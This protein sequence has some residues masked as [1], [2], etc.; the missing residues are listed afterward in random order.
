MKYVIPA[1]AVLLVCGCASAP[2]GKPDRTITIEED[3]VTLT[4]FEAFDEDP[5]GVVVSFFTDK[6]GAGIIST[7][8]S[9]A[10]EIDPGSGS[11]YLSFRTDTELGF[12]TVCEAGPEA[13]FNYYLT[14]DT[15]RIAKG[16]DGVALDLKP[17]NFNYVNLAIKEERK[18]GLFLARVPV[19]L[20][21]N[22]W[23]HVRIPFNQFVAD[24]EDGEIDLRQP[25]VLEITIPYEQ[26]MY[27]DHFRPGGPEPELLVDNLSFFT[28][29]QPAPAGIL[30]SFGDDIEDISF[31][32]ELAEA[33]FYVDYSQSDS[34][35][36]RMTPGIASYKLSMRT[37]SDQGNGHFR[38]KGEL[39]FTQDFAAHLDEGRSLYLFLRTQ[40]RKSPSEWQGFGFTVRSDVILDGQIDFIDYYTSAYYAAGFKAQPMWTEARLPLNRFKGDEGVLADADPNREDY[41]IIIS[42]EIPSEALRESLKSGVFTFNLDL[43]NIGYY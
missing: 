34:G 15:Q 6:G 19:F 1:L 12:A 25:L 13:W 11:R 14:I 28:R 7:V 41:V 10:L 18:E 35:D 31:Y 37:V 27:L 4:R 38:I 39:S 40:T 16:F 42:A 5:L 9:T 21:D 33:V 29:R 24:E 3:E 22:E 23:Q 20:N 26:N 2:P 36:C 17:R 32:G 8:A 43:D 30:E